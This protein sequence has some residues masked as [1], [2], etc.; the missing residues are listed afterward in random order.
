MTSEE[1]LPIKAIDVSHLPSTRLDTHAPLWWGNLWGLVIETV[2]FGVLIAAYFTVWMTTSPFPPPQVNEF[3]I[4][5]N[6][7]PDLTVPTIALAVFILSLVPDIWLDISAR[8][9]SER[10]VKILLIFTLAFNIATIVLRFYE[11][12]SL[13]F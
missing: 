12:H 5:L 9:K 7:V 4:N 2:A 8:A 10:A 1:K 11:F 3:P 6:P 13:Y